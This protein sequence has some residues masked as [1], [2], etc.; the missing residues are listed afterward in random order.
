MWI[1]FLISEREHFFFFFGEFGLVDFFDSEKVAGFFDRLGDVDFR[2]LPGS[3][4]FREGVRQPNRT[5]RASLNQHLPLVVVLLAVENQNVVVV[6]VGGVAE[7]DLA[8]AI[9]TLCLELFE[10]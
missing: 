9:E 10:N 3:D 7:L 5:L 2:E 1:S 4:S 6:K 8:F